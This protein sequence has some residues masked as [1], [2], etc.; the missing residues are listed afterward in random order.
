MS[1]PIPSPLVG[2]ELEA[3]EDDAEDRDPDRSGGDPGALGSMV[4]II[5]LDTS[6][7]SVSDRVCKGV[8][9]LLLLKSSIQLFEDCERTNLISEGA[10]SGA[11]TIEEG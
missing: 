10:I 1:V 4:V 8:G 11:C 2:E 9:L 6:K 7:S 3:Y 5:V